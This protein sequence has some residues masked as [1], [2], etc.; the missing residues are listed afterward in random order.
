MKKV[1]ITGATGA[2]GRALV[3]VCIKAGYEVLAVVHRNSKRA[4]ELEKI[5]HCKVLYLDLSEYENALDEMKEQGVAFDDLSVQ[6]RNTNSTHAQATESNYEFFFHLA[7]GAAFGKDRENL[8]L[9]LENVR[10]SL[11]AV[12]FAKALGCSTFVGSGSQAEYGRVKGKLLPETPTYPETGYGIAKLCAGQ[13]ARLAC[14]QLGLKNVWTRILSVYG[15]YDGELSLISVAINDMMNNRETFFTPCDQMWDYV[16]SEDAARAMLLCAQ[17]G[18]HGSVYV[19]GSGEAHPLKEYI[20]KIAEITGY[21][22]EI[23]FGKRPY[24]DK[25]VM[26]LQADISDLEKLGFKPQVSFEEGIR[27]TILTKTHCL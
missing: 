13:M 6:D 12:R 26:Y 25:Q 10:A 20:K 16:F 7:W 11:A 19:I 5:E 8:P 21:K 23:G 15:P 17:K 4:S 27:K 24:N 9:Q 3:S 1:V 14:E 18:K 2:I 22:K